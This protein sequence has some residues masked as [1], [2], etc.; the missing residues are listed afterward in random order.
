MARKTSVVEETP[1]P[2][3]EVAPSDAAVAVEEAKPPEEGV[4]ETP[5]KETEKPD[6]AAQIA[7]LPEDERKALLKEHLGEE[8]SRLEQSARD[9]AWS[10]L[11]TDQRRQVKANQ[12]LQNTLSNLE[13]ADDDNKRAGHIQAYADSYAQ[14]ASQRWAAEALD[15]LRESLGVSHEEH[16]EIVMRL[17]QAAARDRRVATFGDYVKQVTGEKFMPKREVSKEIQAEVK[18]AM[19]E[20]QG[21]NIES[22]EA[23]V[24]TG[25]GEPSNQEAGDNR[26]ISDPNATGEQKADAFERLYGYRPRNI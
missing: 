4:T 12:E 7:E 21:K 1:L 22:Q 17:H 15:N 13:V 8:L 16:S 18:A 11:Q 2:T 5:P 26:I 6:F 23:P 3:E 20:M 24:S 10:K 14:S 9:T 19:A 25:P